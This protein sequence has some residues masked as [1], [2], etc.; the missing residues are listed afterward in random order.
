MQNVTD[1]MTEQ[2]KQLVD[3]Q[4]RTLEPMRV[5][6]EVAADAFEQIVRKNYAV[7]GD[8]L[9]Y[10][11]KQAQLPLSSENFADVTSAQMAE[12]K[13]L[14]EL[15]STRVNEYAEIAQQFSSKVKEASET[16]SASFK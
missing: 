1:N 12:S 16:V 4:A 15:M 8:V 7:V 9:E 11:T 10:S 6:A 5:Y 13:A 2:F 14:A 3:M